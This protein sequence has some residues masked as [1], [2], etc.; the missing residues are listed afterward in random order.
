M[1]EPSEPMPGSEPFDPANELQRFRRDWAV[2]VAVLAAVLALGIGLL[3]II[4]TDTGWE[5]AIFADEP[6]RWQAWALAFVAFGSAIAA[7]WVAV[8]Y[9]RSGARRPLV[10]LGCAL[11]VELAVFVLWYLLAQA[12]VTPVGPTPVF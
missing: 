8:R 9:R 6:Y 5:D 11:A 1:R 12:A 2:I 4:A 3:T 7:V 10:A